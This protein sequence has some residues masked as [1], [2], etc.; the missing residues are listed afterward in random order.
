MREQ[1]FLNWRYW[2]VLLTSL[3]FQSAH[4]EL[5]LQEAEQ[6][7]I[8]DDPM[9]A[10][11]REK[12]QA[13]QEQAV[14]DG[15]LPDPQLKFGL[16]NY[17][18]DTYSRTQEPMTQV[19]VGVQQMFPP[20]STLEHKSKRT[21]F[22]GNAQMATALDQELK[23]RR[24]V[25]QSWLETFYWIEAGRLVKESQD[26]FN[27][28]V[29]ITHSRY[30]TGGENQQDVIRAELELEMLSDKQSN[31]TAMEEKS[32]AELA[33]W[34]GAD[35]ARQPL[36]NN[37]P[38]LNTPAVYEQ[39]NTDL[40]KHPTMHAENAKVEASQQ[41]V[42]IAREAYKPKWMLDLS[43]GA[44]G[45][46]NP[47]GSERADFASAMVMVDVPLFTGKRQ[48]KR[49]A[50]SQHRA[51]AVMQGRETRYRELQRMLDQTHAD[52][53]RLGERVQRYEDTLLPQARANAEASLNAYQ[54][55]RGDFTML[56]RARITELDTRLQALRLKVDHA[57]AQAG[58]LYLG[59]EK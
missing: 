51:N 5:G 54:S 33:R 9:L 30:A 56:M 41:S 3:V 21:A 19:K 13:F 57:K 53:V 59:G 28:L 24:A 35:T 20:G 27:Q 49:L 39:L 4:A 29:N 32:R 52:W 38:H 15:Q 8:N 45:G 50:A 34:V 40:E 43:Y 31:I 12:A 48:D 18:T 6:L 1:K 25:R 16:L 37:F 44:R 7:A 22:M 47:D 23:I 58:L 2:L 36:G 10:G 46:E 55:D 11:L 26:L 14:A 42:A 17:P